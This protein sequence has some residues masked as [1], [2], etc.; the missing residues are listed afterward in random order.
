MNYVSRFRF[1]SVSSVAVDIAAIVEL[2]QTDKTSKTNQNESTK[3]WARFLPKKR[4]MFV[5]RKCSFEEWVTK[6]YTIYF[7]QLIHFR[8]HMPL[9]NYEWH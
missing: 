6:K 2:K 3:M 8:A 5:N 4:K 1:S 7:N 9:L